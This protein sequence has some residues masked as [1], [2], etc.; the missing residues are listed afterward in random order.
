MSEQ[1]EVF[2]DQV[3]LIQLANTTAITIYSSFKD[4]LILLGVPFENCRGKAYGDAQHFQ[5]HR[6]SVAVRFN[7]D[8]TAAISV[9]YLANCVNLCLQEIALSGKSIKEALNFAMDTI[10]LIKFLPKRRD[11]FETVQKQQESPSI[12]GIRSLCPTRWTVLTGAMQA[13]VSNYDALRE[14]ME[15]SS[16][17]MMT[18]QNELMVCLR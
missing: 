8:N 5:E 2:E 12:S 17:G 7:D 14:T 18:V 10:Q 6:T 11:V 13:I 4:C 3:G 15:I 1:Y 16:H 9:N